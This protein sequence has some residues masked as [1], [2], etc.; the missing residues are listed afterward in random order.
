MLNLLL[1]GCTLSSITEPF[2]SLITKSESVDKDK[3]ETI[4]TTK[5]SSRIISV[6]GKHIEEVSIVSV[7]EIK[8]DFNTRESYQECYTKKYDK[9][10]NEATLITS[11]F[12][13]SKDSHIASVEFC[14]TKY[15]NKQESRLMHYLVEYDYEG[16]TYT[17]TTKKK[18]DTDSVK[19]KV[20]VVPEAY[21]GKISN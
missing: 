19:V 15:R 16:N 4:K 18:P 10:Q 14:E 20:I 21:K 11:F 17:Y 13:T 5:A 12:N 8:K 9:N 7:K 3:S 6:K 2:T 1:A